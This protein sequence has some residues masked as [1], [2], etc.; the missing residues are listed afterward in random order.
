MTAFDVVPGKW[1]AD[2]LRTPRRVTAM[3]RYRM[4]PQPALAH[5]DGDRLHV[6]FDTPQFAVTP[7]QAVVCYDGDDV[8]C[9]GTI[10]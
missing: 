5:R 4:T 3:V 6:T 7:G 10:V 1:D 2:A 9:G 8:V